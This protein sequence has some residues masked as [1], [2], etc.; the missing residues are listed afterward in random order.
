MTG[1]DIYE[2]ALLLLGYTDSSAGVVADK[3]VEKQAI[4]AINQT[5][6]DIGNIEPII[7]LSQTVTADKKAMEVIPYGVAMW[8]SLAQGDNNKNVIFSAIYNAKR[9]T[10][11]R[12][13]TYIA[14]K[15]PNLEG[16]V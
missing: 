10:L 15:M 8:L 16:I 9:A 2:L 3:A 4:C 13:K 7:K 14:E 6:L 1:F 12:D 5:C 11:K